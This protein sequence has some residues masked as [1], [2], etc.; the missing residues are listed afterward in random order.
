VR[1]G[2]RGADILQRVHN[3]RLEECGAIVWETKNTKLWQPAWLDK[4]K[5]D[6]RAVAAVLVSVTLPDG[7][8]GFG[9]ID[10]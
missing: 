2:M 10:E 4:L 8:E 7:I 6:Q 9:R 3:E 5:Q 1:K